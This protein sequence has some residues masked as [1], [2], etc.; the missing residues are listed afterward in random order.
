MAKA[1]KMSIW[2]VDV[3]S[4]SYSWRAY[5]ATKD[6]AETAFKK[7]WRK[8]CKPPAGDNGWWN[9]DKDYW[10]KNFDEICAQEVNLGA[11]YMDGSEYK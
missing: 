6:E 10:G 8:H 9:V 3:D 1:K 5:G 7:M 2:V 4:S 11:G